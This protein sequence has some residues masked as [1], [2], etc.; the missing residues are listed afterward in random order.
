MK[1]ITIYKNASDFAFK[2]MATTDQVQLDIDCANA[3]KSSGFDAA[4]YNYWKQSF[5]QSRNQFLMLAEQPAPS[6]QGKPRQT[7]AIAPA[8]DAPAQ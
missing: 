5:Q 3:F 8:I 6:E 7:A 2:S 4:D 1:R